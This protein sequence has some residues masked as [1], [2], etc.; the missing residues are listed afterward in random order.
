MSSMFCPFTVTHYLMISAWGE[1]D[2]EAEDSGFLESS[3]ITSLLWSAFG[4]RKGFS[5]RSSRWPA[6]PGIKPPGVTRFQVPKERAL[7]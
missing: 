4:L 5:H 7:E 3:S 6:G 1:G 2:G